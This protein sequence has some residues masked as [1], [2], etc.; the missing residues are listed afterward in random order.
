M[1]EA[2]REGHSKPQKH[3]VA[4][5]MFSDVVADGWL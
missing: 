4:P 5:A 3:A 1:E 2:Q